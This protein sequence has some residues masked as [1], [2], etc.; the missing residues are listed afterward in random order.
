MNSHETLKRYLRTKKLNSEELP[1]S[2]VEYVNKIPRLDVEDNTALWNIGVGELKGTLCKAGLV[3]E[4]VTEVTEVI[5]NTGL[6]I[7]RKNQ[8]DYRL[9]VGDIRELTD[10]ELM[11]LGSGALNYRPGVRSVEILRRL[12]GRSEKKDQK[13]I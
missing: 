4:Q 3:R 13:D 5:G 11:L 8:E 7:D 6:I 9:T 10:D 1:Q 2:S 12:F